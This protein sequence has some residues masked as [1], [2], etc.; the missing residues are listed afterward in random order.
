M[1]KVERVCFIPPRM[2]QPTPFLTN[3]PDNSHNSRNSG[4]IPPQKTNRATSSRFRSVVKQNLVA[5]RF[6][7]NIRPCSHER[8][9]KRK[10]DLER[11]LATQHSHLNSSE[12]K[13]CPC[14]WLDCNRKDANGF[15]RRDKMLQHQ[16]RVHGMRL[17]GKGIRHVEKTGC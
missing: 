3:Y 10:A 12:K 2:T 16:D 7:C 13:L 11:H 17:E 6:Y 9:F 5:S 1:E 14:P 15:L 8:H 4:E